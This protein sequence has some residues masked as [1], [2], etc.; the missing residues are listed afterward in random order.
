MDAEEK[1]DI[2]NPCDDGFSCDLDKLRCVPTNEQYR[3]T[4][5]QRKFTSSENDLRTTR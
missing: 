3:A 1:C 2:E 5:H 4:R